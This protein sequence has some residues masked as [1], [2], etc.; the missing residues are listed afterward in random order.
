MGGEGKWCLIYLGMEVEG[1]VGVGEGLV[2]E[3][4]F[5]FDG[6]GVWWGGGGLEVVREFGV[7][8]VVQEDCIMGVGD[9]GEVVVWI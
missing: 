5:G 6:E 8:D 3:E 1:C 7:G 4:G 2:G 9:D